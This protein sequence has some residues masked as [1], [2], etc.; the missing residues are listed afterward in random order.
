MNPPKIDRTFG[1]WIVQNGDKWYYVDGGDELDWDNPRPCP[2]CGKRRTKEGHDPCIAELPGVSAAC[3][4]H[5]IE[6]G[7]ILFNSGIAVYG[8]NLI[9]EN[10]R[11][12]VRFGDRGGDND[13]D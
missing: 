10:M 2:Q 7:Y 8:I 1:H 13:S 12:I 3:C 11:A 6:E 4:G 9:V 5:G